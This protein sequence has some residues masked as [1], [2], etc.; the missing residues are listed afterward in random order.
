MLGVIQLIIV[1]YHDTVFAMTGH[2]DIK[3]ADQYSKSNE[4]DQRVFLEKII[5]HIRKKCWLTAGLV[6]RRPVFCC[7][8]CTIFK[9]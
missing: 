1:N 5:E 8:V 7:I 9:G 2:K 4:D 6:C 3:L